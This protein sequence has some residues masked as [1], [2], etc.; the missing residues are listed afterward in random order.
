MGVPGDEKSCIRASGAQGALFV[1][2]DLSGLVADTKQIPIR[3]APRAFQPH[4][5]SNRS[6][7][8]EQTPICSADNWNAAHQVC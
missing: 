6:I 4:T 8:E 3:L 7:L 1:P 2:S 5:S